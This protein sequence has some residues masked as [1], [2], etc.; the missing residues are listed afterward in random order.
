ME[1]Y[2]AASPGD[3][4][5]EF[6]RIFSLFQSAFVPNKNSF[7]QE[8]K[9]QEDI[10]QALIKKHSP[11]SFQKR[12]IDELCGY[13]PLS[14]LIKDDCVNEIIVNNQKNIAFEKSGTLHVLP[15]SFL[16]QLTFNNSIEKICAEAHMTL[17]LKKPFA[18]GKWRNFR[19][20]IT[21]P[22]LIRK[23]FHLIFRRT[24]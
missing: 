20:H 6:D 15:D 10:V 19:V 1:S 17:N 2:A 23:D 9:K 24:S 5:R 14:L 7:T 16:S 4:K 8:G 18:E 3:L 12:L 13:G 11:A 21:R 22:P